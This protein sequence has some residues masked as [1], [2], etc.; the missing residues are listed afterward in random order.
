MLV[1]DGSSAGAGRSG[2]K[3][4]QSAA[5]AAAVSK[6]WSILTKVDSKIQRQSENKIN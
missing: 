3:L 6:H 2:Q 5:N 1:L 4:I